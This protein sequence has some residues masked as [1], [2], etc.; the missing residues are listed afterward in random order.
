MVDI[1][2]VSHTGEVTIGSVTIL[3][4]RLDNGLSVIDADSFEALL[5][6][7][8]SG[9]LLLTDADAMKLAKVV[10]GVVS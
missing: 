6:A 4:H 5:T 2:T 3:V 1:P 8:A 7:M 9:Q 10:K